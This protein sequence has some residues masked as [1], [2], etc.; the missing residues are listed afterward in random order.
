MIYER[1]SLLSQHAM[2]QKPIE[3]PFTHAHRSLV[4]QLIVILVIYFPMPTASLACDASAEFTMLVGQWLT[5]SS[6][7]S[8]PLAESFSRLAL[9]L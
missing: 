1:T 3:T 4:S 6:M 8:L 5:L 2:L 9:S 7:L